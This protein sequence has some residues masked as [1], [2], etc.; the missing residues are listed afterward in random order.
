MKKK[1]SRAGGQEKMKESKYVE[2]DELLY[3]DLKNLTQKGIYLSR[4]GRMKKTYMQEHQSVQFTNLLVNGE[5]DK[6]LQMFDE[7]VNDIYERLIEQ[8]KIKRNITEE[9]K[10]RNQILWIQEMNNIESTVME[11]IRRN[12]I[13]N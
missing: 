9:L 3:P 11:F 12:Y 13:Y 7:E 4:F 1:I 2:V 10:E 6:Y 8:Y 5:L